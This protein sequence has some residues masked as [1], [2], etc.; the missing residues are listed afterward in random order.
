MNPLAVNNDEIDILMTNDIVNNNDDD[1]NN[2]ANLSSDDSLISIP[3]DVNL[4]FKFNEILNNDVYKALSN[5]ATNKA[6]GLDGLSPRLIRA[7]ASCISQHITFIFNLS[8]S[9]GEVPAE[10]KL[11]KVIHIHK[12]GARDNCNNYR[13]ISI[14][15]TLMKV[16]ERIINDRLYSYLHTN[17]LLSSQ[18]SG[19]R[20]LHSTSTTLLQVSDY[21]LHNTDNGMLTGAVFL[22][23]KKAF[24]TVHHP[25]LLKKLN[26]LGLNNVELEWFK[27]YLTDRRQIT[28]INGVNSTPASIRCG[29]PQGSILG[30]LLFIIFINDLPN[31]ITNCT[32][33]MYA[34]DTAIFSASKSFN[35]IQVTLQND[36]NN[37]SDWLNENKLSLNIEKTKSLLFGS[38]KKLHGAA[39]LDIKIRDSAIQAVD[40]FKYLG[41]CF[42][43]SL[44]WSVHIDKLC[45]KVRIF[46][47]M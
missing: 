37:V 6:S 34:D 20:P 14:L 28:S 41:V 39:A 1:L 38:R 9:L 4:N 13:P 21:I 15:P 27:S 16:F 45:V 31:V 5:L 33:F 7:A 26:L 29:V 47:C 30:P 24:D 40:R 36:L 25:T 8:L 12:G 46:T 10:W 11:G 2:S 23:L 3:N 19:F 43:P 22:D 42:D 44:T 32:T 18:Q 17:N 35:D